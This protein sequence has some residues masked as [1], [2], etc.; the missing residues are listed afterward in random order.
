M[1]LPA[2]S[3]IK[4]NN[5]RHLKPNSLTQAKATNVKLLCAFLLVLSFYTEAS[6]AYKEL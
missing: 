6:A 3:K 1:Y 4:I 2:A 5:L